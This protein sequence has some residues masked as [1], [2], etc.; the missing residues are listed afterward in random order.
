[1]NVA[2]QRSGEIILRAK[3]RATGIQ[4][5]AATRD[6]AFSAQSHILIVEDDTI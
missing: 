6:M 3:D 5:K 1:V 4:A 2:D